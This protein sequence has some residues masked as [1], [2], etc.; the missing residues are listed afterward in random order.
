M[1]RKKKKDNMHFINDSII[2]RIDGIHC[3]GVP[4]LIECVGNEYFENVINKL[5][6]KT[7]VIDCGMKEKD[8]KYEIEIYQNFETNT[9]SFYDINSKDLIIQLDKDVHNQYFCKPFKMIS[10]LS[11]KIIDNYEHDLETYEAYTSTIL[12]DL[13]VFNM[14]EVGTMNKLSHY[15]FYLSSIF[16]NEF[17][18][19][20]SKSIITNYTSDAIFIDGR[21]REFIDRKNIKDEDVIY[22]IKIDERDKEI[23]IQ[24][25]F[26]NNKREIHLIELDK[27]YLQY[28]YDLS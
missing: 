20:L 8:L 9:F 12:D 3:V 16:I 10:L 13:M 21:K 6:E 14:E 23:E 11:F 17:N 7:I 4:N 24:K 15:L 22:M 18:L 27:F 25:I 1:P 19:D 2:K 26:E 5:F 28:E